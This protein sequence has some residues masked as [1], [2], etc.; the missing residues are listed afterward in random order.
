MIA[1][2]LCTRRIIH[3]SRAARSAPLAMNSGGGFPFVAR[4]AATAPRRSTNAGCRRAFCR[5]FPPPTSHR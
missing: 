4:F 1:K 3:A 5:A 2:G